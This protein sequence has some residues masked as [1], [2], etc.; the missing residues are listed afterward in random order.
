V[1]SLN[2]KLPI[3][4]FFLVGFLLTL[5]VGTVLIL[6]NIG[7]IDNV[8]QSTN[9]Y[10]ATPLLEILILVFGFSY[11]FSENLKEK[12][13][14]QKKMNK[15]QKE[16]IETQENERKRIGQD[17]HDDVGNTLAAIKTRLNNQYPEDVQFAEII[18]N[19]IESVRMISHNL[20]PV[21]FKKNTLV[22]V[23]AQ[24]LRKLDNRQIEVEFITAG[25]KISLSHEVSLEIYRIFNEVIHNMYL[26][27]KA[28]VASVQLI[29]QEESIVLTIE[30]NGIGFDTIQITAETEGIGLQ[31]M[32]SRAKLIG[33]KLT[34][35][36]DQKGT[37]TILE[38]PVKK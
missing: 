9:I 17:L 3:T 2:K 30:D 23:L 20:M 37:L 5:F 33:A 8:N 34:I 27:A 18:Q 11:T 31:N 28:T 1:V 21:D 10:Y 13:N 6:A 35:N 29:F 12:F 4:Y 22:D 14:I 7:L 38:I 36:S 25:D 15:T 24:T 19:A 16:I 26:H 32:R